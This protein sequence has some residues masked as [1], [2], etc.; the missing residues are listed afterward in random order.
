[1]SNEERLKAL[2]AEEPETS[3]EKIALQKVLRRTKRVSAA[4]DVM[5]IFVGWV[6]VV[7]LGLGASAYSAKQQ[8]VL[9][10]KHVKRQLK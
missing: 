3:N 8:R 10:R 6:W 2:W 1:M 7:L 9:H 4:K 5:S